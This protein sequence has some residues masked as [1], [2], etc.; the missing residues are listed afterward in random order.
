MAGRG[1]R[2]WP[3]E[4]GRAWPA[5]RGWGD[6]CPA[7]PWIARDILARVTQFDFAALALVVAFGYGGYRRGLL[8]FVL[9]LTGGLL[10]FG[11]AAVLAPFLAPSV[12]GLTRLPEALAG[13]AAVIALTAVLRFVFQFAVRELAVALRAIIHGIP[14][15]ALLDRV[16]GIVPGMALGSVFV[17]AVALTALRLPLGGG[18][19]Q[20]VESSWLA[21]T[22]ITRPDEVARQ[23]R[24]LWDELVL[25]PP[26]LGMLPLA[27]GIGGLWLAAFAAFRMRPASAARELEHM[28][29]EHT[30]YRSGRGAEH[31][32]PL[33][34]PRAAL[35]V[36]AAAAMMAALLMMSRM[37]G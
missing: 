8:Q 5:P 23:V 28:P 17:L 25:T 30:P 19:R 7:W 3:V 10:A 13:P 29:T 27:T 36:L 21:R 32:D 26:R 16:L 22:V 14:P 37:R 9:Q 2:G 24:R 1:G 20:A 6:R 34:V 11:L 31:A 18:A 33:A 15:L 35:G 12:T 4:A